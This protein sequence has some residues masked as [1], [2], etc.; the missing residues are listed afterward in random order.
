MIGRDVL[1]TS[2]LDKN[3]YLN[4]TIIIER[5]DIVKGGLTKIGTAFHTTWKHHP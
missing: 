3:Y 5:E 2:F 4:S 1:K